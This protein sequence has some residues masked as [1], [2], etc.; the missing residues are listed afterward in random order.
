ME[1]LA[2]ASPAGMALIALL[3]RFV[4]VM[5]SYVLFPAIGL[6]AE[7]NAA[8]FAAVVLAASLGSAAGAVAW[9]GIGRALGPARVRRLVARHGRWALFDVGLYDRLAGAYRGRPFGY[10]LIG[11]AVPTVRIWQ[12]LPAGVMGVRFLPFLAGTACGA[13]LWNAPLVLLGAALRGSG[14]TAAE[15]GPLIL[16]ALLAVEGGALLLAWRRNRRTS[17][18]APSR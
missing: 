7:R 11:Q 18:A 17:P 16:G 12:A 2:A 8:E 1:E 13:L 9:Y 5:P 14:M 3:E 6:A 10:S 15:L 4:P